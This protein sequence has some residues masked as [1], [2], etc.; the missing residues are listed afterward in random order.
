MAVHAVR[1]LG[2]SPELIAEAYNFNRACIYRWL[3]QYD[4]GGYKRG[5]SDAPR[6][7]TVAQWCNGRMAQTD[8]SDIDT[9]KFGYDTNLWT[10]TVLAE[11][12]EQEFGV[13][14]SDSTVSFI[15][16]LWD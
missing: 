16:K 3:R 8:G 1:V 14:V 9:V 4:E 11:L 12:L 2:L 10:G 7:E 13:T 6:G 15:L 5:K